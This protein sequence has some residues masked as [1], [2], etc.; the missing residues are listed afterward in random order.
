MQLFILTAALFAGL[1][2]SQDL[3]QIQ[4]LPACGQTCINNMLGK[5][6]SLGCATSDY[7]CLCSNMNF[8]F[9]VRDCSISVCAAANPPVDPT[10][11]I[12]VGNNFCS[13]SSLSTPPAPVDPL[14]TISHRSPSS[15]RQRFLH[16]HHRTDRPD[17]HHRRLC[18]SIQCLSRRRRRGRCHHHHR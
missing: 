14:L 9:G 17:R 18:R 8:G 11:I 12:S 1:T 15:S 16:H 2:L 10:Q 5:A 7:Q 4:A 3:S 13:R 6:S